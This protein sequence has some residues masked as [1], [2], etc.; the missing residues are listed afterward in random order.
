MTPEPTIAEVAQ[1]ETSAI[2]EISKKI[3]NDSHRLFLIDATRQGGQIMMRVAAV[4]ESNTAGSSRIFHDHVAA[5]GPQQRLEDFAHHA[6]FNAGGTAAE[7]LEIALQMKSVAIA[8]ATISSEARLHT[9]AHVFDDVPDAALY[10]LAGEIVRALMPET[11]A[12]PMAILS[13]L[14]SAVG[15]M[16]G[17]GPWVAVGGVRHY[18]ILFVL[19]IGRSAKSRK[20][21]SWGEIA[22]ILKLAAPDW[23]KD[24]LVGGASTGEG[25]IEAVKDGDVILDPSSSAITIAATNKRALFRESEFARVLTVM[26]RQDN[27]LSMVLRQA[28]DAETLRITTRK[29]PLTATSAHV[30]LIAHITAEELLR[31]ATLTDAYSGFLNRYLAVGVA[32]RNRLPRGGSP[33]PSEIQRFGDLL[34]NVVEYWDSNG[35]VEIKFTA[36][37]EALWDAHYDQL[38]A[39][40]D[41]V[42]GAIG[43]RAEAQVLRLSLTYAILDKSCMIAVP[44]VTAALAFW[45]HC[46]ATI[47]ALWGSGVGADPGWAKRLLPLLQARRHSMTEIHAAVGRNVDVKEIR[48]KLDDWQAAGL[49]EAR[50][51]SSGSK[52]GRPAEFWGP[53]PD[54]AVPDL[55]LAQ[56]AEMELADADA[57]PPVVG[58][59]GDEAYEDWMDEFSDAE[60]DAL[61]QLRADYEA[62]DDV[63]DAEIAEQI[64]ADL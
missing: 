23:Y 32:R 52:G 12:H 11:E 8:I 62:H 55:K 18:A 38:S 19:I 64:D 47:H 59:I 63:L 27:T 40:K 37:A 36:E 4:Y 53:T 22:P 6:V 20:G 49:I 41:G 42:E 35:D 17:R 24:C 16:C 58:T 48:Q 25:M 15:N 21:Q 33:D 44:H 56:P 30:S 10:G 3:G 50:T 5:N 61:L 14:L 13:S 34:R 43:A 28:W 2:R 45:A 26:R 39:A 29:N 60:H 9:R 51:E 46:E 1:L 57:P 31:L 7:W 54:P